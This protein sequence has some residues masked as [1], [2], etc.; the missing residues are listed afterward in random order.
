VNLARGST[1]A[2]RLDRTAGIARKARVDFE[3]AVYHV[4]DRGDRREAIFRNDAERE[5]FRL[6]PAEM[7][8]QGTKRSPLESRARLSAQTTDRKE[9]T[10]ISIRAFR[11]NAGSLLC[12]GSGVRAGYGFF[13]AAL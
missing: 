5:R 7:C 8:V 10:P 9:G 2:R 1:G 11:R 4:I 12:A 6:T 3:G 13:R